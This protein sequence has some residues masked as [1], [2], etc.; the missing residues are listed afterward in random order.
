MHQ[1]FVALIIFFFVSRRLLT[2]RLNTIAY[3]SVIHRDIQP[4]NIIVSEALLDNDL[5]WSDEL[6]IDGALLKMATKCHITIIDFG[7]ARALGPDDIKDDIG[8][9]K[10]HSESLML[11]VPP[12]PEQRD[13]WKNY[14]DHIIDSKL[15]DTTH[16]SSRGRNMTL[17]DSFSRNIVRELS[18]FDFASFASTTSLSI[19]L[20]VCNMVILSIKLLLSSCRCAGHS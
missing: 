20:I 18:E 14:G 15:D 8:L 3:L 4:A 13:V 12:T 10:V 7:F 17:G 6:D 11:D 9:K 16:A 19:I 2:K 1:N 5:W